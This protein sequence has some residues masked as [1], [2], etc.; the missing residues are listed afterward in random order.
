MNL[1]TFFSAP[2]VSFL[3]GVGYITSTACIL[4]VSSITTSLHPVLKAG[5]TPSIVRP[6]SG[7]C[8]RRFRKFSEKISIA[9]ASA[10]SDNRLR[11][12]LSTDGAIKRLYY[13]E[14]L[15]LKFPDIMLHLSSQF[16]FPK[17]EVTVLQVP[18]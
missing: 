12:S 15:L 18:V 16:S 11:I 7:G 10:S 9:C 3:G 14:L 8:N 17:S 4:P 5:S 2:A 13:P 1:S 6:L